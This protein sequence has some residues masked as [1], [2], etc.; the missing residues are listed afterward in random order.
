MNL[1]YFFQ[2]QYYDL[3]ADVL[4]E[5]SHLTF[6]YLSQYHYDFMDAVI[7]M[8]TA[9]E[10]AYRKLDEMATRHTDQLRK[11]TKEVQ[12]ARH[13]HDDETVKKAVNEYDEALER[14]FISIS[15][16]CLI[17]VVKPRTLRNLITRQAKNP[18]G[19]KTKKE[20]S[21]LD[22]GRKPLR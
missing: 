17:L 2:P 9:K 21:V 6:K 5:N 7:T 3:A 1:L 22:V 8:Q 4:A 16:H 18:H 13:N 14:Y 11:L 15:F 12:E 19:E 20:V 10:E